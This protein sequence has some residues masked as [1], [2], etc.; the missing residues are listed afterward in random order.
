MEHEEPG[1]SDRNTAAQL[2]QGKI[3][4]GA[5]SFEAGRLGK[6]ESARQ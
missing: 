6:I 1:L 3:L 4:K 5:T 2:V